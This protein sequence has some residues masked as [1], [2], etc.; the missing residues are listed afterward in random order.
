MNHFEIL[1][2]FIEKEV[3]NQNRS[4]L[5]KLNTLA[6][7]L[8]RQFTLMER[9]CINYIQSIIVEPVISQ[10]DRNPV[11]ILCV[12]TITSDLISKIID[13]KDDCPRAIRNISYLIRSS[14]GR[15]FNDLWMT[16][17]SSFLFLR[18]VAPAIIS[19]HTYGVT[20]NSAGDQAKY[21]I[22]VQ[23]AKSIHDIVTRAVTNPTEDSF[24]IVE[25]LLDI[26]R[27]PNCEESSCSDFKMTNRFRNA[28]INSLREY[29]KE[30][31]IDDNCSNEREL[32]GAELILLNLDRKEK[33]IF[34]KALTKL[35]V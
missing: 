14:V 16:S 13:H 8:M 7:D 3:E 11:D 28:S 21:K 5:F 31:K 25:F 18:T 1:E 4:T 24:R 17:V 6:T 19:P 22:Q 10:L 29:I 30:L 2:Y 20:Y 15:R 34:K 35:K 12:N 26:S 27:T 33:S 32:L 9:G 23:I